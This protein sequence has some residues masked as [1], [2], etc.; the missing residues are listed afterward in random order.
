MVR[1]DDVRTGKVEEIA[2]AV[3][4][5]ADA[6]LPHIPHDLDSAFRR[7]GRL[8]LLVTDSKQQVVAV[9][10]MNE[11]PTT[12]SSTYYSSPKH[13]KVYNFVQNRK[14][15]KSDWSVRHNVVVYVRTPAG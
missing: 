3:V 9:Q 10:L 12:K 7:E 4:A 13:W 2:V 6:L 14:K 5:S 1:R 8:L 11:T 15:G